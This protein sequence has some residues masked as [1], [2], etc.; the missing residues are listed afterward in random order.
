MNWA[1]MIEAMPLVAILRGLTPPEAVPVAAAL[2][3]G[4]VVC[5]EVPLNSPEP[6]DSIAAIRAAYDGALLVGAGTVLT[7]KDVADAAS[8]GAQFIVSPDA[9]ADVIEATKARGLRSLPGFFTPTEAFLAA[10]AGADALKLFPAEGASPAHLKAMT[11][12]LPRALP[13]L[14]VGGV[15]ASSMADWLE[16]GAVGFGIGSSIYRPGDSPETVRGKTASLVSAFKAA[17]P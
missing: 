8:A 17:R 9:Q 10:R 4:G 5:L 7:T 11:A 16:A 2:K 12:V 1:S 13:I 6:L 3:D 15:T 14:A